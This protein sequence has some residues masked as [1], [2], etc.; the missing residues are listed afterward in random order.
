MQLRILK[1]VYSICRLNPDDE[2]PFWVSSNEFAS[3]TRTEAELSILCPEDRVPQSIERATGWYGIEVEGPLSFDQVGILSDL[4]Q[5]LAAAAIPVF[6]ISTY[7]TDYIFVRIEN[8]A[9]AREVLTGAG[10]QFESND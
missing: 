3:I 10:H 6:V 4:L 8:L 5:P 2:I 1:G 7:L 9:K